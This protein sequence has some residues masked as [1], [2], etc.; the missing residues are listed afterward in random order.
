MDFCCSV[1]ELWFCVGFGKEIDCEGGC[2]G[3]ASPLWV[4][5]VWWYNVN[6]WC[7][8]HYELVV[9]FWDLHYACLTCVGFRWVSMRL[10][11]VCRMSRGGALFARLVF[12]SPIVKFRPTAEP[13]VR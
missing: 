4:W 7:V 3:Y 8:V 13:P 9:V 12:W 1:F 5:S 6:V 2:E 10:S 11:S